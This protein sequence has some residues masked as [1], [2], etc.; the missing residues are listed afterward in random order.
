MTMTTRA[1]TAAAIC[2]AVLL[3]GTACTSGDDGPKTSAKKSAPATPT[4]TVSAEPADDAVEDRPYADTVSKA[5]QI[6]RKTI[7][8]FANGQFGRAIPFK[9]GLHKGTLGIALN[10]EG[11]GTVKVEVPDLGMS[12]VEECADGKVATI[13]NEMEISDPDPDAYVQIM[14]TSGVRWSIS[15]G[16]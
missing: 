12:F 1:A 16:Q 9:G 4:P 3:T 8:S 7:A 10:C 5:P 13:Y 15:A 2:A 6:D 11:K 14:G